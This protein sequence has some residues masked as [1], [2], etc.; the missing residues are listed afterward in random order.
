MHKEIGLNFSNVV[1]LSEFGIRSI[2]VALKAIKIFR[3]DLDPS[4][5]I[6]KFSSMNSK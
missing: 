1:G 3:V 6:L 5:T 4:I 2:K